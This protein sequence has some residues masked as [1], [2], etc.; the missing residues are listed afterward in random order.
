MV[1]DE[2]RSDLVYGLIRAHA[3][4]AIHQAIVAA[5][6][7]FLGAHGATDANGRRSCVFRLIVKTQSGRT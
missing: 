7:A 1:T 4:T 5:L 3:Q 2:L 6:N